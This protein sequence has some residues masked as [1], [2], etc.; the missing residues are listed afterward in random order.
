MRLAPIALQI[1]R[2][3]EVIGLNLDTGPYLAGGAARATLTQEPV[4]DFD[5][6]FASQ[7]Q[8]DAAERAL[9]AAGAIPIP[10]AP[11]SVT[12]A[13][14]PG[15]ELIR[16]IYLDLP[17]VGP[18]NIA[19]THVFPSVDVLLDSFD[20]TVCQI[21]TDGRVTRS[22]PGALADV[23]ARRLCLVRETIAARIWKYLGRGYVLGP[24]DAARWVSGGRGRR[25]PIPGLTTASGLVA[26]M[27]PTPG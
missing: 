21:A 20:F 2:L 17:G 13:P 10:R 5:V 22:S 1:D 8:A 23:E 26:Q 19:R 9:I 4:K 18:V 16:S 11:G 24:E 6:F 25:G 14:R 12:V 7:E 27:A 3:R 15:S